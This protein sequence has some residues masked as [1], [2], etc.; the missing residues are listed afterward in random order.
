MSIVQSLNLY[1]LNR[2][3]AEAE[4]EPGKKGGKKPKGK[5]SRKAVGKK[6]KGNRGQRAPGKKAQ[7]GRKRR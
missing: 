5:G 2:R 3:E 7:A 1:F 4:N 6:S